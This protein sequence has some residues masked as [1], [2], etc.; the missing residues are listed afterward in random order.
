ME[1]VQDDECIV[2]AKKT[3]GEDRQTEDTIK[4]KRAGSSEEPGLLSCM[5]WPHAVSVKCSP[6]WVGGVPLIGDSVCHRREGELWPAFS[7]G[8]AA[9]LAYDGEWLAH[10][11]EWLAHDG[12]WLAKTSK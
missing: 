7:I 6:G 11:G 3:M 4:A 9:G 8:P 5:T 10:D 2:C 1:K 12:E